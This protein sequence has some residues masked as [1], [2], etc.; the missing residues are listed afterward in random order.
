METIDMPTTDRTH[1]R[2]QLLVVFAIAL[3]AI[4]GTVGLV[5][6]GGSTFVQRRAEQN[7]ADAAAMAAGYAYLAGTD[8]TVAAHTVAAAN[9]YTDGVDNTTVTVTRPHQNYFSGVLGFASWDVSTTATVR[10]GIPNGAYGAMPLLFNEDAFNDPLNQDPNN[11]SF[12]EPGTGT[13][14][15]PQGTSQFNWT[16]F[17]TASGNPCNGNSSDISE[18]ISGEGPDTTIYLNDDIGPL[19]AGVHA[20]LF[21]ELAKFVGQSWPVAI[22][23]ND[24]GLVGWAWFTI[25]GSVGGSTKQISGYFSASSVNPAPMVISTTGGTPISYTGLYIVDLIN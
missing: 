12:D 9:G 3:V 8:I 25:T 22:V 5:I 14:D 23:N 6:D 1:E 24:G 11:G 18:Y 21:D 13:E 19:N 16:L 4:V 10:A 2:G 20:D 15:V 17:C 7:V